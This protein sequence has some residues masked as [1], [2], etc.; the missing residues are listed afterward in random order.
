MAHAGTHVTYTR[1]SLRNLSDMAEV[2]RL[3]KKIKNTKRTRQDSTARVTLAHQTKPLSDFK[4]IKAI[5]ARLTAI[6]L[7]YDGA[8]GPMTCTQWPASTELERRGLLMML[9]E[10]DEYDWYG[11]GQGATFTI[12]KKGREYLQWLKSP[13]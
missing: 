3:E 6:L 9:K 10:P 8:D 13:K 7:E 4:A 5:P 1:L 11:N 2:A 12:T